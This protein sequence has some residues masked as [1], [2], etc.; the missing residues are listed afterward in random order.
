MNI[1]AAHCILSL[2]KKLGVL[3]FLKLPL[4]VLLMATRRFRRTVVGHFVF[5]G[6]K[7]TGSLQ[8]SALSIHSFIHS[9]IHSCNMHLSAHNV[10]DTVLSTR[11]RVIHKNSSQCAN[12]S[13]ESCS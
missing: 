5:L 9:F 4:L 3:A 10:K 7:T 6:A 12:H 11:N 2:F 1:L 13:L 8:M